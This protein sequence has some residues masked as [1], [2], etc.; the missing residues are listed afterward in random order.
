MDW[1]S[2][3]SSLEIAEPR[4]SRVKSGWIEEHVHTHIRLQCALLLAAGSVECV[5]CRE[6]ATEQ[7]YSICFRRHL[8]SSSLELD[9]GEQ[10]FSQEHCL[11][12]FC[13]RV[14]YLD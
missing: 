11:S 1:W 3:G 8:G 12:L 6:P 10:C 5:V 2:L 4:I 9:F 7:L 13:L 14:F